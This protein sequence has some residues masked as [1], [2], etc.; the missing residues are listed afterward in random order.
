MYLIIHGIAK[1]ILTARYCIS[2]LLFTY[3]KTI[4]I[5]R[6]YIG[7]SVYSSI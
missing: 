2:L 3:L 7:I 6:P 5:Y 4:E 1:I